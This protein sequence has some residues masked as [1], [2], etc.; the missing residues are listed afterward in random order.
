ML[1]V[2]AI[3]MFPEK[4]HVTREAL[5]LGSLERALNELAGR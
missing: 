3:D 1:R 2:H 5:P 4:C